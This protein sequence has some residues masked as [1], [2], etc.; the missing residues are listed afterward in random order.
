[1]LWFDCY[2]I[3]KN[4]CDA[5]CQSCGCCPVCE[6]FHSGASLASDY[7]YTR[8]DFFIYWLKNIFI[9]KITF[10]RLRLDFWM[11]RFLRTPEGKEWKKELS[12]I[13]KKKQ[14]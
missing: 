8:K 7:H 5:R 2:S 9:D 4:E 12:N 3:I 11:W 13:I 1:M 14:T 6:D 10:R